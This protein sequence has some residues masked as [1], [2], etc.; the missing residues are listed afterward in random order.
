MASEENKTFLEQL[1]VEFLGPD[2]KPNYNFRHYTP[3]ARIGIVPANKSFSDFCKLFKKDFNKLV[4]YHNDYLW[5]EDTKKIH[6]YEILIH[7]FNPAVDNPFDFGVPAGRR[8]ALQRIKMLFAE[9]LDNVEMYALIEYEGRFERDVHVKLMDVIMKSTIADMT[10]T[11]KDISEVDR[12]ALDDADHSIKVD[13]LGTLG[14]ASEQERAL[15]PY[16]EPGTDKRKQAVEALQQAIMK[17]VPEFKEK[18][19]FCA[20]LACAY[21]DEVSATSRGLLELER[22][23]GRAHLASR[24]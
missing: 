2:E 12:H 3:Y 1:G 23:L 4:E 11:W 24:T 6:R 15:A 9:V 10:G 13:F 22:E 18:E 20:D 5:S 14:I 16:L 17:C 21:L 7:A 8:P 19:Q